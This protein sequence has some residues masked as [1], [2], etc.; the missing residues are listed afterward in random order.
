MRT[1]TAVSAD[2]VN[3]M[4]DPRSR[5]YPN[6][7]AY[8]NTQITRAELISHLPHV[9]M[10]GD[11]LSRDAY[12]SSPLA[13][14]WRARTRKDRDW[15][16]NADPFFTSV[17][18]LFERLDRLTPL[19]ATEYGGIGAMMEVDGMRQSLCRKVLGTR[20][21]SAQVD[22][23]LSSKR[24]PDLILIWIGHN[25]VDW[26]WRCPP[27]EL[28]QPEQRL[29]SQAEWF[30]QN[31]AEQVR[32]LIGRAQTEKHRVA[33]VVY[34]L[35]DFDSYFKARDAAEALRAEDRRLFPRLGTD[36][37]YYV[38]MRPAYRQNLIRLV[39]MVNRALSA[40]ADQ[41]QA[42]LDSECTAHVQVHYSDA[43]ADVD[44]S[45]VKV[46]H[47]VDGWHPSIEG[48]NRFAEAAF[49]NL[50]SILEFVG[51]VQRDKPSR[52]KRAV[53]AR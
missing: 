51:I 23:V 27:D 6:Y 49:N 22:R 45:P 9:A 3:R 38:S 31:Y 10:I 43:L 50:G 46:I 21:F 39:A 11:S 19:V 5:F 7:S 47:A 8:E 25:N 48:H 2:Y 1:V 12:I 13:T 14:L 44:L 34:G 28:K 26:A 35:V 29:K 32:R 36:V 33:I 40:M 17:Y 16:L 41:L 53:A 37:K 15:F 20:N 42:E 30:R 24:F 18:S 4:A 52:L